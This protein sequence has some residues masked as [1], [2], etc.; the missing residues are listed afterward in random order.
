MDRSTAIS[1]QPR[2]SAVKATGEEKKRRC[3]CL[4]PLLVRRNEKYGGKRMLTELLS[5]LRTRH[6]PGD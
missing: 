6:Y 4:F 1:L 5:F 2:P 3:G